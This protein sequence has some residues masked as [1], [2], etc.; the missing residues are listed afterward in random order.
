M[1]KDDC[2]LPE[3][4]PITPRNLPSLISEALENDQKG[5]DQNWNNEFE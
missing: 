4:A 3:E 5:K 2:E 1:V